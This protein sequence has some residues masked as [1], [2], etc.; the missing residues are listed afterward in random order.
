MLNIIEKGSTFE[1]SVKSKQPEGS[2][3][4][5]FGAGWDNPN[6]PVDLDIVCAVLVDGKLTDNKNFVYFGNRFATGVALSAS[7]T[8]NHRTLFE[9]REMYISDQSAETGQQSTD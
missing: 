6:G 9:E 7:A 8:M 2:G 5:Y 1:L 4:F 3:V